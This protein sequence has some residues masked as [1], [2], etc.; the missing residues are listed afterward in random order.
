MSKSKGNVVEPMP[1]VERWGADSVRLILLFA[2]PFEDDIDR[3]LIAGDDTTRR[4]GVHSW[5]SRAFLAV[6]EA[7]E[8]GSSVKEPEALVRATHRAIQ[9]VTADVDAFRINTAISKLQVLTNEI[10]AALDAGSGALGAARALVQL[11]G[12]F[13]PFAA[14]ELWRVD[15]GEQD[16]VH[17][18]AWPVFDPAL[19]AERTVQLIVQ[20]DGR[21]RDRIEVAADISDADALTL[22]TA[23]E[24]ALRAVG[25]R[26]IVKEIVRAP[27][28]VNLV[29]GG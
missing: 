3:K 6:G 16:S 2:G 1:L 11:L 23:S 18:A 26:A 10:R 21:V 8:R 28:L 25:E 19:V 27:K 13:A 5:L 17:V 15:L 22:A 12:P 24:N 20:V 29:T 9:G 4:P 14:E 7:V